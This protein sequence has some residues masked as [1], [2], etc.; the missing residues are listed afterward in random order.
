MDKLTKMQQKVYDYIRDT[1]RKNGV[2][3]TMKEICDALDLSSTSTAHFHLNTLEKKGYI[4]RKKAK[5]RCI[6]VVGDNFYGIET[7]D[8][9]FTSVPIIGTVAAGEPL[10]AQ[11]NI[12]GFFPIPTEYVSNVNNFMLRIKGNSMKDAG[13][14]DKDIVLVRQQN[15]A[16][17]GDIIIALIDDSATCKKYYKEDDFIRLQPENPD[18]API[19]VKEVTILGK[20]IG[21]FR[22]MKH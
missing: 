8:A 16:D 9:D 17:N 22:S 14:L 2:P 5:T 20:V 6:E 12:E 4:R 11:E 10:Y 18:Y 19:Y 13:I 21:L 7:E 1:I 3:P 15:D